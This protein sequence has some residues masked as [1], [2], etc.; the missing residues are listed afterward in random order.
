[1]HEH[2]VSITEATKAVVPDG[3]ADAKWIGEYSRQSTFLWQQAC[4]VNPGTEDEYNKKAEQFNDGQ[5]SLAV[6]TR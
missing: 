1:M 2:K 4:S 6:K 3:P 5:A